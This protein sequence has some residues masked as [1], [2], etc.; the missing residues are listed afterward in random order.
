MKGDSIFLDNFLK[1]KT[2]INIMMKRGKS[3]RAVSPVI[4][5]VL[6]VVIVLIIATLI[7]L[8]ARGFVGESVSKN[9]GGEERSADQACREISLDISYISTSGE[10]QIVNLG[11][12]PV[13]SFDVQVTYDTSKET[14]HSEKPLNSGNSVILD[15]LTIVGN[16]ERIEVFPLILGEGE[17]QK[18]AYTCKDGLMA[19]II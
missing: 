6:L 10:L 2:I 15:D 9:I 1:Y 12:I 3:K 17:S 16:V 18:K 13:F 8:W 7:F 11:N 14:L 19:S 5:T 4:A